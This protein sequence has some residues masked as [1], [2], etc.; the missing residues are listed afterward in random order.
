MFKNVCCT[1]A[2]MSTQQLQPASIR[3]AA[4]TSKQASIIIVLHVPHTL[5]ALS[6]SPKTL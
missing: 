1:T 6:Q 5:K 2:C 4:H 3:R